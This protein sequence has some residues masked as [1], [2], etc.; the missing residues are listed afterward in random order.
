MAGQCS[1]PLSWHFGGQ[2]ARLD[3]VYLLAK[4]LQIGGKTEHA[5]AQYELSLKCWR[6]T[7]ETLAPDVSRGQRPTV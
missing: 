3:A 4:A 1:L 5:I 2:I 7:Y 6:G